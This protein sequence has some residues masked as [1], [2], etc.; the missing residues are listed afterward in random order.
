M[1][2]E[3]S[4]E[5]TRQVD[6]STPAAYE[7]L[8]FAV[9]QSSRKISSNLVAECQAKFAEAQQRAEVAQHSPEPCLGVTRDSD[10]QAE[11][12]PPG[13][14]SRSQSTALILSQCVLCSVTSTSTASSNRRIPPPR[15]FFLAAL[16][17][18]ALPFS[19]DFPL[20]CSTHGALSAPEHH[21]RFLPL[22]VDR[23]P[24]LLSSA[25]TVT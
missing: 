22:R 7:I 12:R 2:S 23:F 1:R 21:Q 10:S 4:T 8:D 5:L 25:Q 13:T 16:P 20:A 19:L 18:G 17:Q 14:S 11:Q 24:F 6:K 15:G 9:W 3:A